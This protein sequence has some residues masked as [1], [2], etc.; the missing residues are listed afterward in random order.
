MLQQEGGA[1][2]HVL[3][4]P[5]APVRR[6]QP[7]VPEGDGVLRQAAQSPPGRSDPFQDRLPV[8]G[9]FFFFFI[10]FCWIFL[11]T[12]FLSDRRKLWRHFGDDGQI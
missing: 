3:R 5:G 6:V 12:S 7:A 2:P 1:A 10:S 8:S 11:Q 4:G 9:F